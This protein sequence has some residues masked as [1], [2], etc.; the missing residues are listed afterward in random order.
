MGKS[1]RFWR[2]IQFT[3]DQL[4]QLDGKSGR[5]AYVAVK[6]VVY[7]VSNSPEWEAATHFGLMAGQDL[8]E[9]F[10]DCHQGNQSILSTLPRVGIMV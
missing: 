5:P 6:G 10:T 1:K 8:S 3:I 7:D 4:A 9:E 2:Q